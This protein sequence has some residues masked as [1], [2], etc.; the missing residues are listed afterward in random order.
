MNCLLSKL[1]TPTSE[2]PRGLKLN[3]EYYDQ[4]CNAVMDKFY[5]KHCK[6]CEIKL[7]KK[8]KGRKDVI[9]CEKCFLQVS[10]Y[11]YTPL[12]GFKL[13]YWMFG[14]ALEECVLQYPKVVTAK[15]LQRRL[16]I[17]YNS[18]LLL[19]RRIQLLSADMIPRIKDL[20]TKKLNSE[21]DNF[22]LPK[23]SVNISSLTADKAIVNADSVVLFSAS[24]RANKGRKRFK[25]T[26]LT[27][28]VY[29]SE[30]LGGKQIGTLVHTIALKGGGVIYQAVNDQTADTLGNQIREFI[31][32]NSVIF[33]DEGYPFLKGIYPN[34]R[35]VNH[36]AKSK[37]KRYHWARN[38]WSKDGVNN[39]VAE[40]NQSLLKSAFRSYHY[41]KPENASFYLDEYSFLSNVKAYGLESFASDVREESFFI[42][43]S[44]KSKTAISPLN[45]TWAKVD[46]PTL[47]PNQTKLKTTIVSKVIKQSS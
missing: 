3:T 31:P 15:E 7:T 8:V 42:G 40:G 46:K 5:P 19:K 47:K 25:H 1:T 18:A 14:Y 24:Q 30:K 38:R 39:Q 32:L 26:G 17:A 11:S 10:R 6:A 16:G 29:L 36:S 9:R 43:S 4:V 34:H 23:E 35:M 41:F 22:S 28:S 33:T 20:L 44:G 27:A 12:H 37:D 21:F 13:P 2:T 45:E